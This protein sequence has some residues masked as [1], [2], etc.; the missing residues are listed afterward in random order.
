MA[1]DDGGSGRSGAKVRVIRLKELGYGL[2]L[3]LRNKSG[4][5]SCSGVR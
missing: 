1:E 4:S 2:L 5:G 3:R